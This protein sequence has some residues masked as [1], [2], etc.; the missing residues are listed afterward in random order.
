MQVDH[1]VGKK[2]ILCQSTYLKKV[3]DRFK[4]T[5]CKPASIPMNPGVAN[6]LLSYNRNADKATINWYQPA[7]TS[8][9]WPAVY[10]R[11]DIAYS[12]GIPSRYCSNPGLTHCNLVIEIFRYLSGT[13]DLRIKFTADSEDDLVGYTDSD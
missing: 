6:F 10:T 9:M 4:M 8:L 13:L 3:L 12:V 5:E 1:V 11:L 2:I 7:I